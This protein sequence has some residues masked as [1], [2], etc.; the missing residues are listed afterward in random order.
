M[1]TIEENMKCFENTK[2]YGFMNLGLKFSKWL[3]SE[4]SSGC[5]EH[6]NQVRWKQRET[7]VYGL[8]WQWQRKKAKDLSA[9]VTLKWLEKSGCYPGKHELQAF[10]V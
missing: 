6:E 1:I 4:S 3:R 2:I 7:A 10:Q 5:L 9:L 8:T